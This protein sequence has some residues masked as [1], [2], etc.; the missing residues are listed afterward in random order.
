MNRWKTDKTFRKQIII[1]TIVAIVFVAM[2]CVTGFLIWKAQDVISHKNV[3][4][5]S[6]VILAKFNLLK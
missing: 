3:S 4:L 5:T 2:I 1:V 6:D